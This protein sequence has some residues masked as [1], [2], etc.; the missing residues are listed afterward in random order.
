MSFS[1]SDSTSE[2]VTAWNRPSRASLRR[3][4]EDGGRQSAP[5]CLSLLIPI[6]TGSHPVWPGVHQ[7]DLVWKRPQ[8]R[9]EGDG[10]DAARDWRQSM[11]C[12]PA[13][14]SRP[15]DRRV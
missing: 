15:A 7:I 4:P 9:V 2:V 10:D 12:F 1:L 6:Q 3:N 14:H 13:R 5:T 8:D 11:A